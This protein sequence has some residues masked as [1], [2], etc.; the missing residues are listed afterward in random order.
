MQ[1]AKDVLAY[2]GS[3]TEIEADSIEYL[4]IL[5]LW[6]Y[7]T[8]KIAFIQIIFIVSKCL[9]FCMFQ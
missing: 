1:L 7:S 3:P 5:L 6:S 2:N 9:I 8:L 4:I